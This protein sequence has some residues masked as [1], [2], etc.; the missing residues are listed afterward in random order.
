M[1]QK[2]DLEK[3]KDVF[4][5]DI[6]VGDLGGA[7]RN[8]KGLGN[9][10]PEKDPRFNPHRHPYIAREVGRRDQDGNIILP[11]TSLRFKHHDSSPMRP[12]NDQ[13]ILSSRRSGEI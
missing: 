6:E 13:T 7:F 2:Y 8:T 1:H 3:Q 11:N 4:W 9:L 5:F 10:D 12:E